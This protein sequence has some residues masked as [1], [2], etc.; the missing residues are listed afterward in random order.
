VKAV[1]NQHGNVVNPANGAYP[2]P[3][4]DM[5]II[6]LNHKNAMPIREFD[7][8]RKREQCKF[9][10]RQQTTLNNRTKASFQNKLKLQELRQQY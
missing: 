4:N 5:E 2:L 1:D 7:A 6:R 9:R 8:E 10:A 3:P